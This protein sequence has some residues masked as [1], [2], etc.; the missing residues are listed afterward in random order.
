MQS[1]HSYIR[2]GILL[3]IVTF[4]EILILVLLYEQLHIDIWLQSDAYFLKH[5]LSVWLITFPLFPQFDAYSRYQN[6]KQ[7]VDLF[8]TNGFDVRFVKPFIKSRC[9]RDAVMAAAQDLGY[10]KQ[11]RN[12]FKTHGYHWYHLFPDVM[13]VNPKYLFSKNF[14]V[15]TFFTKRYVSKINK[16]TVQQFRLQ[17]RTQLLAA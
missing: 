12:L 16:K 1:L 2:A 4:I 15:T 13:F 17:N 9:Q 7:L 6:Y 14:W 10:E 3:H 8:Y 5:I 11:C